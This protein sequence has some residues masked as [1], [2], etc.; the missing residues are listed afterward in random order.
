MEIGLGEQGVLAYDVH[1]ARPAG[2][3]AFDHLRHDTAHAARRPRAPRRLEL[4]ERL[5]SV[6][7]V[8]GEV[9]RNAAGVAAALDVVLAAEGRDAAARE[10]HLARDEREIQERMRVVDAVDVLGDAHTPDQTRAR[11]LGEVGSAPL[12]TTLRICWA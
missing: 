6:I 3:A 9:R 4:R 8:T 2:E 10:A 12:A 7:L 1:R 11:F 5:G